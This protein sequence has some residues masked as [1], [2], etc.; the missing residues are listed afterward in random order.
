MMVLNGRLNA[1]QDA[2]SWSFTITKNIAADCVKVF[3]QPRICPFLFSLTFSFWNTDIEKKLI[4]KRKKRKKHCFLQLAY[5]DISAICKEIIILFHSFSFKVG[6]PL[7]ASWQI[8]QNLASLF[9]IVFID[10]VYLLNVF[11]VK[12]LLLFLDST[13]LKMFQLLSASLISSKSS[14]TG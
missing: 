8:V 14:E 11:S 9:R 5:L 12:Y 1:V 3:S 6:K 7:L 2:T 13:Q 10:C 4:L